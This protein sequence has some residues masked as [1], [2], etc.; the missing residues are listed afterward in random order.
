MKLRNCLHFLVL[1]VA[2]IL[3][4]RAFAGTESNPKQTPPPA[5]AKEAVN[6]P[7]GGW[8]SLEKKVLKLV[9][10]QGK[11]IAKFAVRGK[12]LDAR[13]VG[14]TSEPGMIAVLLDSDS[15]QPTILH[16]GSKEITAL[17]PLPALAFSIESM[18]LYRDSQGYPQLFVLG[19]NGVSE[20]WLIRQEGHALIRRL[21]L[22]AN[23]P[24]CRV[25][26]LTKL[27]YV[28]EPT[29]G[30]WA[31]D[32]SR[33]EVMLRHL[34][35]P[36]SR[37]STISKNV[38]WIAASPGAVTVVDRGVM[39][40]YRIPTRSGRADI[41]APWP[42]M[43]AIRH[44][45]S[46]AFSNAISELNEFAHARTF[47]LSAKGATGWKRMAPAG[48][49]VAPLP[50]LPNSAVPIVMPV[51]QTDPML[52]FGD[53]ADDPAI[54][55]H[56]SELT[57]SRVLG[58]NK[59]KGL[60][61]YDLNGRELQ[62]LPVGRVN[63]VD[64]RQGVLIDGRSTDI[65]VASHRDDN[66]IAIF[67][68]GGDGLVKEEARLA[69]EFG[70]IY[71]ICSGLTKTK[72]LEVYVNDKDGRFLH[73][74]IF[75]NDER[76][77]SQL[78]RRFRVASQPEACVVDEANERVFI[79][80]EKRGVWVLSSNS[81]Q[82]ANL[83]LIASVGASIVADVEGLGLYQTER[84]NYLVVSSQGN[85]SYVVM[86][87]SPPYRYR[88]AFRVGINAAKSIDGTS[89]T[90]GL[91]VTSKSLG[92]M[93]PRGMLVVHDGYKQM[94]PGPQNF[95]YVSWEDIQKALKLP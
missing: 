49:H 63:N 84:E 1:A 30:L 77:T 12:H 20:Q 32:I 57:K 11:E 58:T 15:N 91:E 38:E 14:S 42:A 37:R 40:Q 48:A 6:T 86:D 8:L 85:D 66:A 16:V 59:K 68:I 41:E 35:A 70:E 69:T 94:P 83:N 47:W 7:Q 71:G 65:A 64:L 23:A 95:K 93:F 27:L 31:Y 52:Q 55:I 54:W 19:K 92:P 50:S 28:V 51:A 62:Y 3:Q 60:F 56:P 2:V 44:G 39:R 53:A 72:E 4:G 45:G 21:A 9:S 73:V 29:I 24:V 61:V 22:P 87:A 82:S 34:V 36:S 43:Q 79:G 67:S 33:E 81:G 5:T 26:D 17:P 13:I 25:D 89:E 90:D 74:R 10:A 75:K 88:G 76:W 18:C 78:L 46:S 80:E